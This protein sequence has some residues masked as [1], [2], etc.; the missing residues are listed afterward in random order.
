[1]YEEALMEIWSQ[2]GE[3]VLLAV[4]V[5]M[6]V[7]KALRKSSKNAELRMPATVE[8]AKL[9]AREKEVEEDRGAQD[10]ERTRPLMRG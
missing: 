1:M 8:A 7:R 5:V 3:I 9:K 2:V 10:D 6:D 4:F